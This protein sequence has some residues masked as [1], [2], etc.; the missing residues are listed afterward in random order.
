MN[1]L[2][3][4]GTRVINVQGGETI[5]GSSCTTKNKASCNQTAGDKTSNSFCG[6]GSKKYRVTF[7]NVESGKT[8]IE[9]FDAVAVCSGLHN[10]P[11]SSIRISTP[12]YPH[13]LK[14]LFI[15]SFLFRFFFYFLSVLLF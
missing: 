1:K 7:M 10:I 6:V 11:R 14:V 4:Y 13:T 5:S 3:R 15:I 9:V 8:F 12:P 2:I